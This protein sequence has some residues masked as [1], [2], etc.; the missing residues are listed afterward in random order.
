MNKLKAYDV[1]LS[2][3]ITE[4]STL[5]S[6][7]NQIIF[8]VARTATKPDIKAAVE[9]LFNVKV[10]AVN[11]IVRKGKKKVFKG[12]VALLSDS[13]KAVV[14]LEDGQSIDVTTGL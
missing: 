11:T 4:K 1:I 13:K 6:E 10:K 2:P 8:N 7:A 5:V 14:T 12:R 3:V 9:A